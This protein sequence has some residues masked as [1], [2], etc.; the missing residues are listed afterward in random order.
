MSVH[1]AFLHDDLVEEVFMQFPLGF[2]TNDKN[3]VCR[4]E[5]SLY[6]LK[7]A[8]RC[9]FDKLTIALKDYG[10]E[11]NVSNYSLFMYQKH[12]T[13]LQL[14]VYVDDHVISVNSCGVINQFK[15]YLSSCFKMKNLG[16]LR[17]FIGIEVARSSEGMYLCER[18]YALDIIVETCLLGVK[19]ISFPLEQNYKLF[20]V[21]D[22][23]LSDLSSYRHL[24]GRLIYLGVTRP[25]LSYFVNVLAQFMHKLQPAHWNVALRVVRYLKNNHSQGIF[26][27]SNT[28]L[29]LSAWCYFDWD[30]FPT[31]HHSLTGWFI[32][33]GGST[34][35][36]K[37]KKHDRVSRFSVEAEYRDMADTVSELLW[38]QELLRA[39]GIDCFSITLHFD[40]LFSNPTC[41]NSSFS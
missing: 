25:K 28:K 26:L 40:S 7:Q 38:L 12:D 35:S 19:P 6:G 34:L 30:N 39:F 5:K 11:Q 23:P 8:P 22:E 17:Y 13:Q 20:S 2:C 37:T 4:L 3:K 9:W 31:T 10:F 1:N 36:W 41:R 15:E 29:I 14:L 32:Q 24:V 21:D 16:V 27:R 33:L 18:K